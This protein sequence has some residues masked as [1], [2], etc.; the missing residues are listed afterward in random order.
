MRMG[1]GREEKREKRDGGK[2]IMKAGDG[3]VY[4]SVLSNLFRH[5]C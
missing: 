4:S 5:F 1:R 3:I 2:K